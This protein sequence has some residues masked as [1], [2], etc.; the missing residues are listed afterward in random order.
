M[1]EQ[2]RHYEEEMA[3]LA[4]DQAAQRFVYEKYMK[5]TLQ[6]VVCVSLCTG[7]LLSFCFLAR[8]LV[9]KLYLKMERRR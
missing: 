8:N 3:R 2:V 1:P 4:E 7:N 9:P 5:Y 6:G